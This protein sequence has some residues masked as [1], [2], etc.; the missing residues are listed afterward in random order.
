[1]M[2]RNSTIEHRLDQ[3]L[4]PASFG[5]DGAISPPANDAVFI[6]SAAATGGTAEPNHVQALRRDCRETLRLRD[7]SNDIDTG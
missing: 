2:G 7:I 3:R 6:S 5:S 1:M 4:R